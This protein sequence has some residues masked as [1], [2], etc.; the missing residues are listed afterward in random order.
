MSDTK[1]VQVYILLGQSNMVGMGRVD[2][3][4]EGSLSYA[5]KEKKKYPYLIDEKGHW[6]VSNNVRH[7]RV[8]SRGTA[9]MKVCKNEWMTVQGCATIGPEMGIGHYVGQQNIEENDNTA[10]PPPVLLLKS[11]FVDRSL[12]W[13]LLPPSSPP[14]DFEQNGNTWHYAGYKESPSKWI[15]GTE[16]E[17]IIP[18]AGI[19]YDGDIANAKKVLA[20][21]DTYHPGHSSFEIAGFFWWQGDTDRYDAGHASRYEHNLV[22]LIHQLRVDFDSP[23]AK[24]V[25]ATLGQTSKENDKG[26]DGQ[27]LRAQVAVDGTNDSKYSDFQGNVATVYS[28]PLCHGGASNTHYNGSAET[29]MDVGEAMGLAMVK[30]LQ[31]DEEQKKRNMF[32]SD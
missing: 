12:G 3:S 1:P 7:V 10:P 20:D 26:I 29:F 31:A 23:H 5:V 15:K 21:L 16:P 22:H 27:I 6:T 25:C 32:H 18:Y 2:G 11:C 30:M 14:F 8:T 24:F 4:A 17:P 13:H 19:Q 28:H 9:P